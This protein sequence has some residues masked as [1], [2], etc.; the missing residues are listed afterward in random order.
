MASKAEL[1][2]NVEIYRTKLARAEDDAS[3]LRAALDD[4]ERALAD[5]PDD[6]EPAP[7]IDNGLTVGGDG[8][9]HNPT[10]MVVDNVDGA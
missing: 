7:E 9:A 6:P 3:A 4:A 2:R 1:A 8:A 5:A 10:V